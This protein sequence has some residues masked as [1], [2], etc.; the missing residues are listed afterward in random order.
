MALK[1]ARAVQQHAITTDS[2]GR[3]IL[4]TIA[5]DIGHNDQ[6]AYPSYRTIAERVGCHYNSVS[7]WVKRLEECGDLTIKKEGKRQFYNIPFITADEQL[8]QP[9]YD[10]SYDN[11]CHNDYDNVMEIVTALSQ[12]VEKLS[13]QVA[14]IVTSW[15]VTEEEVIE[16]IREEEE[17]ADDSLRL[18]P[19]ELA[20]P[21]FLNAWGEWR[22]YH[23]E[24]GK[25]LTNRTMTA[26]LN[27]LK[28]RPV[29]D[30][31]DMIETSIR[32][33]WKGL[34]PPDRNKNNGRSPSRPIP[35]PAETRVGG[36]Y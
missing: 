25:P 7:S 17:G 10:N 27:E 23:D 13:Q 5:L 22:A 2:L 8:S 15:G 12:Q 6:D 26:Q 32:Q 4:H 35:E 19:V 36:L 34:F 18:I 3:F 9:D 16:D 1:H 24:S 11:N 28:K 29:S 21:D 31:V 30:C 14:E 20:S 33:G